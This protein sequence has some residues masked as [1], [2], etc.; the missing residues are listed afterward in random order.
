MKKPVNKKTL[1]A[2][3]TARRNAD[4]L[5]RIETLDDPDKLRA[6]MANAVRLDVPEVRDAAF[7]RLAHIQSEGEPGS[8]DHDMWSAINAIEEIKRADAGKTVRLSYLRRDIQKLGMV[9]AMDKLVSKAG[10]SERFD[11]LIA[12]HFPDLTAEAVVMRH[13]SEFSED[14]VAR[15]TERLSEA[16]FD[17]ATLAPAA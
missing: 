7:R 12:R 3:Q 10:S 8:V 11:E 15:S 14:A 4:A 2:E 1:D 16:G 9:R 17:P 5:A 13:S 6:L